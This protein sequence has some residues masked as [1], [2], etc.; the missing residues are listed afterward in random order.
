MNS[1]YY[2]V[3]LNSN[4]MEVDDNTHI[5]ST[6][7]FDL[8]YLVLMKPIQAAHTIIEYS[9]TYSLQLFIYSCLIILLSSL[10]QCVYLENFSI[11]SVLSNAFIWFITVCFIGFIG[12]LFRAETDNNTPCINFRLLFFLCAF[13]QVPLIF[14]GIAYLWELS[15]LK[16]NLFH[17]FINLWSLIL[18]GWALYFSLNLNIVKTFLLTMLVLVGPIILFFI[19]LLSLVFYGVLLFS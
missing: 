18:W 10:A 8:F 3:N 15:F 4:D 6:S 19:V 1:D 16:I 2:S 14:S 5:T 12:W 9:E 11:F 7:L 13:A 17:A